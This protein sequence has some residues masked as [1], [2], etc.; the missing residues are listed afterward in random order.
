MKIFLV[1]AMIFTLSGC[2]KIY[3]YELNRIAEICGGYDKIKSIWVDGT[4]PRAYCEDGSLVS[5]KD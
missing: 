4:T 2:A 1:V 3:D 5:T